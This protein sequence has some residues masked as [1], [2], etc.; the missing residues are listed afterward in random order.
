MVVGQMRY[1][2]VISKGLVSL[3]VDIY[4]RRGRRVHGYT[5][6]DGKWF[7]DYDNGS[8]KHLMGCILSICAERDLMTANYE[9]TGLIR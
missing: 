7:G 2:E 4:D 9:Q 1:F 6:L 3:D 5:G 8:K